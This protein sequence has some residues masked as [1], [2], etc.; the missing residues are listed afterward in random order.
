V[1][2]ET[3]HGDEHKGTKET[4]SDTTRRTSGNKDEGAMI[5]GN[6]HGTEKDSGES[7]NDTTRRGLGEES[8]PKPKKLRV[9]VQFQTDS[10][11]YFRLTFGR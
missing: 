1:R 4:Y 10:L 7:G 11:R 6:E 9:H 8:Y 3:T 2:F 5:S